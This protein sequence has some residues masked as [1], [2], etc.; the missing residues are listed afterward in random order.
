M[1]T[2]SLVILEASLRA[3]QEQLGTQN[4]GLL[5]VTSRAYEQRIA[6]L[7]SEIARYLHENPAAVSWLL[8]TRNQ[9]EMPE[10]A[11]QGVV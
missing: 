7:Q 5:I 3:L 11:L 9:E 8:T 4:P 6:T 2:R 1:A 10:A